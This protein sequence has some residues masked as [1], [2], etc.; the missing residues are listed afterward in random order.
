MVN[1]E[2]EERAID[3]CLLEELT[4]SLGL[5]NDSNMARPSNI[6][7]LDQLIELSRTDKILVKTLY[8]PRMKAGLSKK[9]ARRV[10]R[11]IITELH[12]AMP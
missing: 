2:R 8:D 9:M 7:D 4:Q 10:A 6:S 5:P 1:A 11:A 12:G 3:H